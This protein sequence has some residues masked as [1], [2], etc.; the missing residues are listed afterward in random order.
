MSRIVGRT[1]ALAVSALF[2]VS[3]VVYHAEV[4]SVRFTA[5]GWPRLLYFSILATHVP[6]AATVVP[7]ERQGRVF[8]FAMAFVFTILL[9]GSRDLEFLLTEASARSAHSATNGT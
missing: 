9:R 3:Y 2:L 8:G 4:G 7:L 6:L 1:G 5:E